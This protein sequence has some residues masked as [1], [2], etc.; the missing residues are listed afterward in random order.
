LKIKFN[1]FQKM[2]NVKDNSGIKNTIKGT[3]KI[4]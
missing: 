4:L 1:K 3:T 2:C